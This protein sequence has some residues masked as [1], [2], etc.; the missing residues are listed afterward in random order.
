MMLRKGFQ[1]AD[2]FNGVT[3]AANR[4][5]IE[6]IGKVMMIK[7]DTNGDAAADFEVQVSKIR[8]LL[9]TDFLF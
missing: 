3:A 4:L 2:G 5:W 6:N 8:I 1:F 7:I 9:A